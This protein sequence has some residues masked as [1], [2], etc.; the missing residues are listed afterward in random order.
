[1]VNW[2]PYMLCDFQEPRI[3]E[4]ELSL[5]TISFAMGNCYPW[6]LRRRGGLDRGKGGDIKESN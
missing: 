5:T 1:M 4:D 6:D 3:E 2:I